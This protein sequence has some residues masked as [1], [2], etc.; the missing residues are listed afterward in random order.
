[1][2]SPPREQQLKRGGWTFQLGQFDPAGTIL[3]VAAIICLLIALQWGGS[4]YP[5][6]NYR[7][8]T[9]L[10][11]FGTLIIAW[12]LSQ[13]MGGETATVPLRIFKERTVAF[14]TFYIFLGSASFVMLV[15]Y[16][17]IW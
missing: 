15:Y 11:V 2:S 9:L 6:S 1:M 5:W 10:T 8:I 4:R 3:F 13:W 14:S 7:Q 16:L 17:P 12:V